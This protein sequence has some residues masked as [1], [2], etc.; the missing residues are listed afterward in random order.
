L[1]SPDEFKLIGQSIPGVDNPEIVA[2]RVQFG[3]DVK[4]PG[5]LYAVV[6]RCPTFG[7]RVESFDDAATKNVPG[8]RYV[9]RVEQRGDPARPSG[10]EGIAVVATSTWAAL[11]GRDALDIKWDHG[12]PAAPVRDDGNVYQALADADKQLDALYHVPFITHVPMEP[13]NCVADVQEDQIE[14]WVPT[15]MPA[16]LRRAL[17]NITELPVEAITLHV[18]RIGGGFGRRL[19]GDFVLETI[20]VSKAV[21]APVQ[22][23]W[24]REDDIQQ[25]F[26]RPFSYHRMKAGLDS[27]GKLLAW[28]HRQA[29][30]SRYAFR[31]NEDPANSEFFIND[32]PAN[33]IPNVRLEYALAPS[34]IRRGLIRAP[35]NNALAFVKECFVDEIAHAVGEDPLAFKLSLL[36]EPRSFNYEDDDEI[37][38]GRMRTVLLKAAQKAG[39]GHSLP[40]GRAQGI[41]AHYTFRSYVAHVAEVSVDETTGQ[42]T[43]HRFYSAVDCGMIVNPDGVSAQVEGAIIDGLSAAFYGEITI[44][45]GSTEQSNFHDYQLLR[46]SE[47]PDI[48]VHII[49]STA[50]PTGIGEPP[51]PPVAPALCNAIFAA[52]G[53]RIRHLPVRA[54]DL[55]AKA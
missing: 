21:S 40:E 38:T 52:T 14:L 48:E 28:L 30:T 29:S 2:G 23:I 45:E 35:G 12:Q 34:N 13:M 42:V 19:A 5:M 4:L 26:Y 37:D 41:A 22:L 39:W 17:A 3:M 10:H 36:G 1:K 7:G 50:S 43:V 49:S 46:M 8:V 54:D 9:V 24:T 53:N 44:S 33:L 15:Q 47:A 20:Q 51:Y 55:R 6:A 32:F 27:E 25:G 11:Q 31:S 18:T 16:I